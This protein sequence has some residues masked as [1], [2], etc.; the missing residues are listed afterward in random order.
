MKKIHKYLTTKFLCRPLIIILTFPPFIIGFLWWKWDV[1]L[2]SKEWF[3]GAGVI[4]IIV[5]IWFFAFVYAEYH[6]L[7]KTEG[8]KIRN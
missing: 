5:T 7:S 3:E 2:F 1:Q 8:D 4:L 6:N